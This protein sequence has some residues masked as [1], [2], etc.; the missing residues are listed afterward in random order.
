MG[1]INRVD[2][3]FMNANRSALTELFQLFHRQ[4]LVNIPPRPCILDNRWGLI[5]IF[6][7]LWQLY[8]LV[9]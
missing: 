7:S 5:K 1:Q 3:R 6:P 4:C 9:L 2:A 8:S